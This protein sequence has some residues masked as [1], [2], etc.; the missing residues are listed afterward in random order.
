MGLHNITTYFSGPIIR[1]SQHNYNVL[2]QML[3]Q[4]RKVRFL[5]F[6]ENISNV[7]EDTLHGT[8]FFWWYI[9]VNTMND[10]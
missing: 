6:P 5:S 4:I 7:E 9:C 8:T 2:Q 10:H 1:K 3:A